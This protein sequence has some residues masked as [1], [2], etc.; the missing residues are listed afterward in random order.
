[1]PLDQH[2]YYGNWRLFPHTQDEMALARGKVRFVGDEVAAVAA[3][4]VDTAEE[5][6]ELIDVEYELLPA[7]LDIEAA[8][9]EGA[10]LIYDDTK[11]NVSVVRNISFGDVDGGFDG[12]VCIRDDTFT[13][14][15]VSPGYLEPCSTLA[16]ADGQGRITLYASVQTPYIVQCGLAKALGLRENEVRVIKPHVGGG[17]GGKMELRAY[18]V[19]AARLAQ[20][21]GRPV[22]ITLSREEELAAGRRRHGVLLRSRVAYDKDGMLLSKEVTCH[23]TGGAYNSMGPT[24]TFLIGNFG[25]MLYR[26]PAY[27]YN[28][29]HV[30]TNSAPSG[31]MR[32]LG[33]PP[34]P[35]RH[36]GADEPGGR[37][38]GTG[39]HR[40]PLQERHAAR[41]HHPGDRHHGNLR[42]P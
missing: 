18:D 17:F 41:R 32:G 37:G 9:T 34:G 12:A 10:P 20:I 21:T 23:L 24:A 29:Y 27:R 36:R 40:D 5:A 3:A 2:G 1:M 33:A 38:T 15:P 6:C 28:G 16:L 13:L 39:S 19:C 7:V 25:A 30:Y 8:L 22:K 26:F 31:A 35:L 14:Q 42:L 11:G 4:D